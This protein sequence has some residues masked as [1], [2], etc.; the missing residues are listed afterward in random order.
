VVN[1]DSRGITFTFVMLI[2]QVSLV[3]IIIYSRN[4]FIVEAK[5]D[6]FFLLFSIKFIFDEILLFKKTLRTRQ[7]FLFIICVEQVEI[8]LNFSSSTSTNK[9]VRSSLASP[10]KSSPSLTLAKKAKAY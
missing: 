5:D 2:V 6:T 10:V 8:L 1:Y 9:L 3:T 7:E 4:V